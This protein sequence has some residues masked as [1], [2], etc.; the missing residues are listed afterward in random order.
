MGSRYPIPQQRLETW[1][2]KTIP[3]SATEFNEE[4]EQNIKIDFAFYNNKACEISL[5]NKKAKEAL[6]KLKMIGQA[7][8]SEL[9]SVGV[10]FAPVHNSGAYRKL[11]NGLP[12]GFEDSVVEHKFSGT[13]RIFCS[14][15][16]DKCYVIAILANHLEMN[17]HRK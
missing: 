14:F 16:S 11:F 10:S 7:R 8:R 15:E 1:D 2:K 12:N 4:T 13:C 9:S 17:K 6:K 3:Y 5:L